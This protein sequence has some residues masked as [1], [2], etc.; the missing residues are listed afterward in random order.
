[1]ELV[2]KAMARFFFFFRASP[3]KCVKFP[4]RLHLPQRNNPQKSIE[5]NKSKTICSPTAQ[6]KAPLLCFLRG[7]N[8]MNIQ[9]LYTQMTRNELLLCYN[10][11]S[12][13]LPSL[14]CHL[15]HY[16]CSPPEKSSQ[17]NTQIHD[18]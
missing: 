6:L 12:I 1:M 8:R 15:K 14:L 9:V 17:K 16:S 13:Y 10:R 2:L 4:Y 7:E 3:L 18:A 5:I 11:I